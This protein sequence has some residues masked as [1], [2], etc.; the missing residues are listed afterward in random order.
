MSL[1]I[2]ISA[3]L[4]RCGKR[5]RKK[6]GHNEREEWRR[7]RCG[8]VV[9]GEESNGVGDKRKKINKRAGE[10]CEERENSPVGHGNQ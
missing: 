9:I 7:L 6:D 1:A 10:R 8:E 5:F 3:L 4:L 2:S